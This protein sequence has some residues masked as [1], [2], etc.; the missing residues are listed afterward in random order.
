MEELLCACCTKITGND[1]ILASLFF[2]SYTELKGS[3]PCYGFEIKTLTG[4][5]SSISFG[6]GFCPA[7]F[8]W[9]N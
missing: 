3:G 1:I 7:L 4:S 9:P 5:F 8:Y 2:V 6:V